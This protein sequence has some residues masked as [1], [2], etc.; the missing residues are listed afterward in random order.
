MTPYDH[1]C[2]HMTSHDHKITAASFPLV[3]SEL[4]FSTVLV[5]SVLAEA[6]LLHAGQLVVQNQSS[7]TCT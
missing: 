5:H 6:G 1:T 2:H 3:F 7:N 4:Y